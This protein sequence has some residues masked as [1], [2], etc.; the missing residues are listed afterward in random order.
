MLKKVLWLRWQN[1]SL[2]VADGPWWLILSLVENHWSPWN[3][4]LPL[5]V[6]S[7]S[8]YTHGKGWLSSLTQHL[9]APAWLSHF[10]FPLEK[11]G[12]RS[13]VS[14]SLRPHGLYVACQAPPSVGFSR[15]ECIACSN[16]V[17]LVQP[18][19]G[20]WGSGVDSW[21]GELDQGF[22]S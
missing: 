15:Q 20:S 8:G 7:S 19:V 12:S 3:C 4:D 11:K 16:D 9:P 6:L 17:E 1:V 2:A 5:P 10:I 18:L 13:F 21:F 14:D 22:R